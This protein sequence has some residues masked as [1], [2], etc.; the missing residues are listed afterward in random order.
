MVIVDPYS[1]QSAY[2]DVKRLKFWNFFLHLEANSVDF[3]YLLSE[4]YL[5]I[6]HPTPQK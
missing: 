4:S 6:T 5:L 1:R 3:E 2:Q